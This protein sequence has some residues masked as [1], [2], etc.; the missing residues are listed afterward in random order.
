MGERRVKFF[1]SKFFLIS[2][3]VLVLIVVLTAVLSAIG[4]PAPLRS[5]VKTAAKPF[6]WCGSKIGAAAD[7]FVRAFTEYDQLKEENQALRDALD[8]A[9]DQSRENEVLREENAWLKEY[10]KLATDHPE[11]SLTDARIIGREAGNTGS[12]LTL[13][14]GKVHGIKNKMAVITEDGLLGYVKETGLDWC[15]VVTVVQ[16]A[17]SV[18]VYTERTGAQGI[19]EGNADLSSS[20]TC[21]MTYIDPGSDIRLGDRVYT[22][23][24]SGSLY[25]SGL[26]LGTVEALEADEATRMLVATIRPAVDLSD[27]AGISRV[28][29][30]S[31]YEV[32]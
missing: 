22:E 19:A 16:T 25:P 9:E 14:R 23:G 12:V 13:D 4:L 6:E 28:M 32:E 18:G 3:A 29:I 17:S 1:K 20:G 7:G 15:K 10:L 5:V 26:L 30:I 21:R 27:P 24:G 31:G 2:V 8:A 11:F